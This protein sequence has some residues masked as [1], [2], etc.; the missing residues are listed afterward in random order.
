MRLGVYSS[1]AFSTSAGLAVAG[2]ASVEVRREDTGALATIYADRDGAVALANPFTADADGRFEFFAAGLDAGYEVTVD[3]GTDTYTVNN[4]PIG[5]GQYVDV[6]TTVITPTQL[7]ANTNNWEPTGIDTCA[8]IRVSADAHDR[9]LTGIAAPAS[10]ESKDIWL[11]N[12]NTNRILLVHNSG[13]SSAGNKLYIG[14]GQ[15]MVLD[16]HQAVRLKY[17]DTSSA[18]R[19]LIPEGRAP[20]TTKYTASGTHT[21]AAGARNLLLY[22]KGAGGSG[23]SSSSAANG[24]GGGEGEEGWRWVTASSFGASQTVT[25][26]AGGASVAQNL[27]TNGNSGGTTSI[28]T[29]LTAVGGSGGS[30]G[31]VGAAGGPGG[32]GGTG[33]DWYMPGANG[34]SGG[35]TGGA[36]TGIYAMGGGKGGGN[37]SA[38]AGKANS[39]GGGRGGNTGTASGAGGTGIVVITEFFD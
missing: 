4:Q 9:Q 5:M 15:D 35:D 29:L 31:N 10:G 39:G 20:V 27:N 30:A 24:G 33:G 36:A 32:N 7:S 22:A 11:I 26:G 23:A 28:G 19:V 16:V 13:S 8:A 21:R 17:D 6:F 37:N 2:G 38:T 1:I 25:I 14:G 12:V 34:M 18:W 3:D